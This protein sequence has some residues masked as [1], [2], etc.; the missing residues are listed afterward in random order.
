MRKSFILV[1][2]LLCLA[3]ALAAGHAAAQEE[4]P[5]A[6]GYGIRRTGRTVPK[7]MGMPLGATGLHAKLVPQG[8][9]DVLCE[10]DAISLPD[11]L[12][13]ARDTGKGTL[14][15]PPGVRLEH[16]A[17]LF[18]RGLKY[19]DLHEDFER[20][21]G[22]RF[23]LRFRGLT[24]GELEMRDNQRA[25]AIGAGMAGGAALSVV[26]PFVPLTPIIFLFDSASAEADLASVTQ[27][28]E[29]RGVPPPN[30]GSFAAT[31]QDYENTYRGYMDG[32]LTKADEQGV[33]MR[34]REREAQTPELRKPAPKGA[35]QPTPEPIQAVPET[36]QPP[37]PMETPAHPQYQPPSPAQVQAE[38]PAPVQAPAQ[39]PVQAPASAAA[40]VADEGRDAVLDEAL[41]AAARE[42][43]ARGAVAR[44]S[45]AAVQPV[46]PASPN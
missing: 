13:R 20:Y 24:D 38:A 36:A 15:L 34:P 5:E 17:G 32:S 19:Y 6:E 29:E 28:A 30:R 46:I 21:R 3:L 25:G 35:G 42:V 11:C 23:V 16:V 1:T 12:Q 8:Y 4:K 45:A 7:P 37:L 41:K 43:E 33:Y 10:H 39:A 44:D 40:P 14:D 22:F 31:Y 27:D 9:V 26:A 18:D 2:C